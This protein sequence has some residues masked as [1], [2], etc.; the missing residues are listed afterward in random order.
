MADSENIKRARQAL[1][2]AILHARI[3]ADCLTA[4]AEGRGPD[5]PPWIHLY[6]ST[7]DQVETAANALIEAT[8]R[9]GQ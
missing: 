3:I 5:E 2:D 9:G 4:A 7:V 8:N 6:S 1:E